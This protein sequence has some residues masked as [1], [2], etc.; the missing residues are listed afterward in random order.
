MKVSSEGF[1]YIATGKRFL[2]EACASARRV[3]EVM[4]HASIAIATDLTPPEGLFNNLI[5]LDQPSYSFGDKVKPLLE[6]PFERTVFLDTDT[7]L[8]EPVSEL[9]S[10]LDRYEIAMA[11]AP[12]RVTAPS[13]VPSCFSECNSG[14]IAYLLNEKTRR[15]ISLWKK[16]YEERTALDPREHDQPALRDALW[17]SDARFAVLPPEYNFRFV[18]P[19][20]AGRGTVKI[21]HGR[22]PN[23]RR[24]AERIN[25]SQ[26]MRVFLPR[27]RD[28]SPRHFQI[29]SFPGRMLTFWIGLDAFCAKW[30][31]K[32][33]DGVLY[34]IFGT[35]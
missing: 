31:A 10:L 19:G 17:Q 28:A 22:H 29:L 30:M 11:H 16:Y 12:M 2:E 9:F 5:V 4:P 20:F 27:L 32:V 18:M 23:L 13:E 33:A 8:C 3:K 6:T 26:S 7:W 1:L 15:L 24:L 25:G 35:R 34:R 14:V 21:I